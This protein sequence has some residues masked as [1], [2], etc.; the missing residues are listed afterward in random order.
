ML[1]SSFM[2]SQITPPARGQPCEP[3]RRRF[4]LTGAN[5]HAAFERAAE[6]CARPRKIGWLGGGVHGDADGLGAI[7]SG[8]AGTDASAASMDSQKA[9]P[10][11]D[12]FM[13]RPAANEAGRNAPAKGLGRWPAAMPP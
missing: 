5:E 13:G 10:K 3:D 11:R 9:V 8:D 12:V 4:G 2:T 6:K 1:P 7:G